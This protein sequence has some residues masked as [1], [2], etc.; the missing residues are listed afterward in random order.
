MR[1]KK[2]LLSSIEHTPGPWDVKEESDSRFLIYSEDYGHIV[3]VSCDPDVQAQMDFVRGD[4][5][6]I[7]AAPDLLE[8]CRGMA[9]ELERIGTYG[10][11]V[12]SEALRAAWRNRASRAR[13]AIAKAEGRA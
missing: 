2:L 12:D 5:Y 11:G 8:V 1:S 4:A 7:A 9:D 13:A 10:P 6:T 3:W